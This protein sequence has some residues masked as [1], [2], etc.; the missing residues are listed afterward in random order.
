[1]V[2]ITFV[3]FY[4]I[5]ISNNLKVAG[6]SPQNCLKDVTVYFVKFTFSSFVML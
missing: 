6:W 4:R 3:D 2:E 5:V 1:M